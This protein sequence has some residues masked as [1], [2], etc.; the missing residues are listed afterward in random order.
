MIRGVLRAF[1]GYDVVEVGSVGPGRPWRGCGGSV[2]GH[3]F[4]VRDLASCGRSWGRSREIRVSLSCACRRCGC[5]R[6][7]EWRRW[8]SSER[9]Q[10]TGTEGGGGGDVE[11]LEFIG[12]WGRDGRGRVLGE[13]GL[14]RRRRRRRRSGVEGRHNRLQVA[15]RFRLSVRTSS[16][17]HQTGPPTALLLTETL[18]VIDRDTTIL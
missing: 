4:N 6:A 2:I 11:R 8:C 1:V 9:R 15:S 10:R 14:G 18:L 5:C 12:D 7:S 17:K 16:W 3:S 13:A